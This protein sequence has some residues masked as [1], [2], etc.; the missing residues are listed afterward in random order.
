MGV[1]FIVQGV[2]APALDL[3]E[4]VD[5]DARVECQGDGADDEERG[6]VVR[7]WDGGDA[8]G[9]LRYRHDEHD[10]QAKGLGTVLQPGA[11][12]DEERG[13]GAREQKGQAAVSGMI[14]DA[15][16]GVGEVP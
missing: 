5:R 10:P 12:L 15:V 2:K 11:A 9:E 7:G 4:L 6:G 14:G 16:V 1:D 13:D 3:E 8:V